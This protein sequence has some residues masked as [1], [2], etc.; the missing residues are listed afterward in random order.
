MS[1]ILEVN[2]VHK[3]IRG[4]EIVQ[5][6]Q[7][8]VDPGE[9]FGFLGPNGAGKTT[10]IRMMV[11][12]SPITSGDILIDG[13]SIQ[14]SY[15][16]A[17]KQV[18]AIVENPEMYNHLSAEKNLIHFARMN[19]K[20]SHGRIDELLDLVKLGHVKKKKVRM[21]SLG[22]KQRLGIAQALLHRPKLLILDEPTN[23]LDPEGIRMVRAYLRRLAEEEGLAV[24]VSSHLLSEMELM[25]DRFAIIQDGQL[26]NIEDQRFSQGEGRLLPYRVDVGPERT[27]AA[28]QII[29]EAYPDLKIE[30]ADQRLTVYIEKEKVPA[31]LRYLM[32]TGFDLYEAKED[33][34]TLEDRFLQATSKEDSS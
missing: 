26:I 17:I 29:K 19:G 27:E 4:K 10:T 5:G 24:I 13:H 23:G 28:V 8:S 30:E 3:R 15:A 1:S 14:K 34:Q 22:M 31:L 9:V 2:D 25:C 32:E 6:L 11:G 12:L 16:K 21:F 33:R 18:G 20:V 7:F